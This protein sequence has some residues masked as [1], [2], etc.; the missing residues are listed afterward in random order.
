VHII[1][2]SSLASLEGLDSNWH[3]GFK[4]TS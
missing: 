2:C 3:S 4:C 1:D